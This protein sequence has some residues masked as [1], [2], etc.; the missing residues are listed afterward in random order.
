MSYKKRVLRVAT[1]PNII[2]AG[3]G[4]NPYQTSLS[5][6]NHTIYLAPRLYE[7]IEVPEYIDLRQSWF[8]LKPY[9]V[10]GTIFAKITHRVL[11]VLSVIYFTLLGIIYTFKYQIDVVHIHSPMYIFIALFAK[12][13]KKKVFITFHA[14]ELHS[15]PVFLKLYSRF[16]FIFDAVFTLSYDL[17]PFLKKYHNCPVVPINNSVDRETFMD[18]KRERKKQF[19]TVGRLE[20]QKGLF[21][22]LDA[23]K[24]FLNSNPDYNLVLIGQGQLKQELID[25][26]LQINIKDNVQFLGQKDRAEVIRYYNESEVF[27]LSSLWEGF[28]KVVLEAMSCGCKVIAT[29]V[30]STPLIFDDSYQY[31][32]PAKN[33]EKLSAAMNSIIFEDSSKLKQF[34]NSRLNQFTWKKLRN[35][36]YS[37]Y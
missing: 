13:M 1:Y 37:Y 27:V 24:I 12:L 2:Q 20:P 32:I 26:C 11:R 36:I 10:N 6:E 31:L 21:Y 29:S 4:Y 25:Y 14:R 7:T 28:P 19:V 5:D 18:Q 16:S 22:L 33:I 15:N 8:H 34:Y 17:V 30:D 23:F 35:T 9:P 3:V